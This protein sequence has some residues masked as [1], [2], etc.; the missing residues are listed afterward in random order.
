MGRITR[1]G[2]E[3]LCKMAN[4][5]LA[6]ATWHKY[7]SCWN[8]VRKILEDKG[9]ELSF[10]L[11]QDM[12]W[13]IMACLVEKG[14]KATT[15]EGYIASL[16]QAHVV[17]GLGGE[18]FDDPLVKAAVKGMKNREALEPKK[19]KVTVTIDMLK[20]WKESIKRRR[21]DYV[22][23]RL[24]WLAICWMFCGSFRPTELLEGGEAKGDVVGQKTL[25]WDDVGSLEEVVG[26]KKE[27][28]V[29]VKLR[30][31][32][33][34]RV[35]PHQVVA[36]PTVKSSLCPVLA[37]KGYVK[38]RGGRGEGGDP[39]FRWK[40]GKSFNT[41]DLGRI[42][43]E[44]SRVGERVTPRDLRAGM[45]TL[46]ARRGVKEE[47]LKMLGRWKSGAFNNYVRRGRENNWRESRD[48]LKLVL[49]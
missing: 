38:A 24:I 5:S 40:N 19:E 15:I 17:R 49:N 3:V 47:S 2:V 11:K 12:L 32:K 8:M 37:W 9:L 23:R 34:M 45:P 20:R 14:L 26:G 33:T 7:H 25:R 41:R 29:Q 13:T 39:V 18:V 43:W 31:P 27:E 36:L 21:D 44:M 46:L 35:M 48:V 22:D 42:L 4:S 28:V 1:G 10:P 30:G 6:N 16:K